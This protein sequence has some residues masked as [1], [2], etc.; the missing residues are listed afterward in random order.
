MLLTSDDTD[1]GVDLRVQYTL[2]GPEE[3]QIVICL[4]IFLEPMGTLAET[5][6]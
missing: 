2:R 4:Q 1:Y 3:G 5:R 6:I